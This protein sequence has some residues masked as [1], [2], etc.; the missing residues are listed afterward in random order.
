MEKVKELLK[1]DEE[2]WTSVSMLSHLVSP[3]AKEYLK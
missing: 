2:V 3:L 1:E